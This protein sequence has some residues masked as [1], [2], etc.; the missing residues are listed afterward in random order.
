MYRENQRNV[1]SIAYIGGGIKPWRLLKLCGYKARA[2][3]KA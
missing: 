1:L 2:V 3:G